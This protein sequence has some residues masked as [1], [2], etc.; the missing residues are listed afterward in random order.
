MRVFDRVG[1]INA[2]VVACLASMLVL[3]V[4]KSCSKPYPIGTATVISKNHTPAT[5]GGGYA[6]NDKGTM[7]Y[8]VTSTEEDWSVIV[9]R[10]GSALSLQVSPSIWVD[11][12]VDEVVQL[13]QY[14]GW[15]GTYN[16][17]II[18]R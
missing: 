11:I 4:D 10:S 5:T 2:V 18:R 17:E 14:R 12:R 13:C 7:S 8:V 15:L 6:I 16:M 3:F 9:E 1:V